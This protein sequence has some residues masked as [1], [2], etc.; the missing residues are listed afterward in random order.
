MAAVSDAEQ[1]IRRSAAW[2]AALAGGLR[3]LVTE[4]AVASITLGAAFLAGSLL[5]I[6]TSANVGDVVRAHGI[7]VESLGRLLHYPFNAYVNLFS[8]AFG[9]PDLATTTV[10]L[11]QAIPLVFTGLSVAFAFRAGLFNIGAEGQLVT[12]AIAATWLGVTFAS[13]PGIL[14]LPLV[15]L[16]SILAGAIWGGIAG[17]LKAYRGAHEVISTI[18]L[19]WIAI[20]FTAALVEVQGPMNSLKAQGQA[21]SDRIGDGGF[22]PLQSWL[23]SGSSLDAGIYLALLAVVLFWFVIWRTSLGYEIRAVGINP[24]A[25]AYGGI[26]VKQRVMLA[27]AIAGGLA[28]L[29]GGLHIADPNSSGT[30]QGPFNPGWGFDGIAVALLGKGNPIGIILSAVLFGAF[31]TGGQGMQVAGVSPHMTELL[32]GIIVL[33]ITLDVVVRKLLSRRR[34]RLVAAAEKGDAAGA[35]APSATVLS[36]PGGTAQPW[37]GLTALAVVSASFSILFSHVFFGVLAIALAVLAFVLHRVVSRGAVIAVI[38]SIVC[39]ALGLAVN[40]YL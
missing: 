34:A 23:G 9:A 35:Y 10:T 32:Q 37:S 25:A 28:G 1:P 26:P 3:R 6:G 27:M 7:S 22:L 12:G 40:Q 8:G 18:M 2:Q 38:Y 16:I 4:S 13:L 19:N 36:T 5:I 15:L 33:F 39:L 24:G 29:A 11:G 30:F 20:Y 14:L 21:V 31:R 17:F